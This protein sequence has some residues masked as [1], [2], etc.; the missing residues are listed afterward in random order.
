MTTDTLT[1]LSQVSFFEEFLP[2]HMEKLTSL[3]SEVHFNKDEVIFREN[4]DSKVFYV[5][6]SG[7]IALEANVAG[8]TYCVQTLYASDVIGWSTVLNRKNPFQ[9]RALDPVRV[10][11]YELSTIRDACRSNPYFGCA[12]FEKLLTVM[13]EC[14]EGTRVHLVEALAGKAGAVGA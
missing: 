4:Q 14:L 6:L 11:A 1:E 7:R 8:Q 10:L 13:A 12:F 3:G 5:I 9:A 2:R